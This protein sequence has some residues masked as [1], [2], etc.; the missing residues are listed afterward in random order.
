MSTA[1]GEK[2]KKYQHQK[3]YNKIHSQA[4]VT[5]TNHP[6]TDTA[7]DS[8]T[9]HQASCEGYPLSRGGAGKLMC[10]HLTKAFSGLF[11]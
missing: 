2:N 4:H 9:Q 1:Q 8:H 6:P 10:A 5:K 7:E 11:R 3:K